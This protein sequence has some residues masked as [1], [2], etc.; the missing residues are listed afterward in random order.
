MKS[1]E[2]KL[3]QIMSNLYSNWF[4]CGLSYKLAVSIVTFPILTTY[5]NFY[6][7]ECPTKI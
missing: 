5:N 7:T 4:I 2:V 6:G 1:E 3:A